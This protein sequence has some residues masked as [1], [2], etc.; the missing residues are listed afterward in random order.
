MDILLF[1]GTLTIW[2]IIVAFVYGIDKFK[3]KRESRRIS[4]K[5]LLM[6]ALF[7]GAVGAVCGMYL[8]RHKTQKPKFKFGVPALLIIN[9]AVMLAVVKFILWV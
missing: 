4:E 7:M 3:A 8:F 6:M 1:M 2:N 9:I 5:C